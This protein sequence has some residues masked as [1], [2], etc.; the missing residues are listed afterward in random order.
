MASGHRSFDASGGHFLVREEVFLTSF[1]WAASLTRYMG[2]DFF[3]SVRITEQRGLIGERVRTRTNTR[4]RI[5][6]I[7]LRYHDCVQF[8]RQEL[9]RR[10]A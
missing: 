5:G 4:V 2:S 10:S 6:N 1:S 7:Q 8:A 9:S 3:D